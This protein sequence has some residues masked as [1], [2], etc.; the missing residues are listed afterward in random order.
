M[1][2][3]NKRWHAQVEDR[4]RPCKC[5]SDQ[6]H[7]PPKW[8]P[9]TAMKEWWNGWASEDL[10]SRRTAKR[11]WREM[12]ALGNAG[13]VV[14]LANESYVRDVKLLIWSKWKMFWE[15]FKV[16]TERFVPEIPKRKVVINYL[17]QKFPLSSFNWALILIS[18]FILK[19]SIFRLGRV[20]SN[21]SPE[22]LF[23][24]TRRRELKSRLTFPSL[25][26]KLVTVSLHKE[27]ADKCNEFIIGRKRQNCV[28]AEISEAGWSVHRI[29]LNFDA[30]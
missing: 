17:E 18:N 3:Y 24:S 9:K 12:I 30:K 7:V 23:L 25:V 2:R 15:N 29:S 28:L 6:C 13:E 8:F 4:S 11:K 1:L 27:D 10:W 16:K 19:C 21:I 5:R 14:R 26:R 20:D 22:N